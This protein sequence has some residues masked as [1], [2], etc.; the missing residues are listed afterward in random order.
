[1]IP[2]SQ[3]KCRRFLAAAR[4]KLWWMTP[5][6][7]VQANDLPPE[8]QFLLLELEEGGPYA[9]VLPLIDEDTFRGTL[10]PPGCASL[11]CPLQTPR[12]HECHGVHNSSVISP[13]THTN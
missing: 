10:R 4:C 7:G 1:M 9:I 11:L 13:Y 2:C 3:L 5:E 6:W 12:S 8:T